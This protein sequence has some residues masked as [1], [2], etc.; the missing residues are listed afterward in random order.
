MHLRVG[1]SGWSYKEWKGSFY[2]DDLPQSKFLTFYAGRF[3]AVEV[4]NT[5]YRLPKREML[6]GW[7][8]QTPADFRFV[9]KASRRITHNAKLDES[10]FD[11]LDYFVETSGALGERRG[12]LLF[13]T[14][15]YLKKDVQVLD[16]FLDRLPGEVRAAFEF[17]STSWFDDEVFERLRASNAA[18]VIADT[19]NEEKDPPF[20]ATADWG[21]LRL[22]REAYAEG[23]L[24]EWVERVRGAE[25]GEAH[26]FFK[27][28]DEGTGPR[29]AARF[30][31]LFRGA[32]DGT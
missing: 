10:G 21:Y 32:E 23:Q 7:N 16:A 14:P 15:P 9:L 2:P 12:P 25:W 17:R 4:N 20:V 24:E 27:H 3:G 11:A 26:T 1:T 8:E 31:R 5:F 18:L 30:E 19:G 28:E 13:Q 6:E 22:R 29:L